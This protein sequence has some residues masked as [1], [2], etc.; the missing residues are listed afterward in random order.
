MVFIAGFG[1]VQ[2]GG[3]DLFSGFAWSE[4]VGWISFNSVSDG[5]GYDYGVTFNEN[6]GI[7]SGYAWSENIGW[8]SFGRSD[9]IGCPGEPMECLDGYTCCAKIDLG[10]NEISG[11]GRALATSTS[12]DGWL[13]LRGA[14]PDYN[15]DRNTSTQELEGFAWGGD[16][17]G[18]VSFNSVSDGS[19]YDYS[20]DIYGG[21]TD[22]PYS[23]IS[24]PPSGSWYLDDFTIYTRD[25]NEGSGSDL[26]T[27]KCEYKIINYNAAGAE[28]SPNSGYL[29]R[30]C[31]DP[32]YFAV[33]IPVGS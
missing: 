2:A 27:G 6:T 17:L 24:S 23:W 28:Q 8:I 21:D 16:I 18:W 22:E 11:W 10:T 32:T 4:T 7:F 20:V 14:N 3:S 25:T 19:A 1:L 9:L 12:W 29:S 30:T 33:N 31:G 26:D 13:S 15:V 5:S